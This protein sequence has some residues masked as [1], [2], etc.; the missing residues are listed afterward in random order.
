MACATL[1][2]GMSMQVYDSLY[3]LFAVQPE[4]VL[5]LRTAP[6]SA[7]RGRQ[8]RTPYLL[9][10]L[11]PYLLIS[12]SQFILISLSPY[13]LTTGLVTIFM[14]NKD[15]FNRHRCEKDF[16]AQEFND[17]QRHLTPFTAI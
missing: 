16:V 8:R 7:I 15:Y 14:Y 17:N 12:L 6:E 13:F 11:Y 10:P 3:L 4:A 2:R 1:T 9:V 5:L